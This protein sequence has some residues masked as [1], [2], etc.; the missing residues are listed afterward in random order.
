MARSLRINYPGAFYHVTSRGNEQRDVF[1]SQQDREKFL[2]Y[3]ESA[4]ERYGA[5]I[6]CW[7]L[8]GN[9]LFLE[10]PWGNLPQVMH[11]ING[12]YTTYFNVKRRRSGHLFQGRYK[13]ILVEADAYALELSRYIHLNPVRAGQAGRPEEYR[14]SS[15]GNYVGL[16]VSPNWLKTGFVL[17]CLGTDAV[18]AQAKYRS[19]VE[20][21]LDKEYE[22]PL[23]E[24]VAGAILGRP[25]FV[26]KVKHRHVQSGTPAN[27]IP[28]LRQLAT[29]PTV[30]EILSAVD[31]EFGGK[32]KDARR[33]GLYLSHALVGLPLQELGEIF[34]LRATA[35]CEASRRMG[36]KVA[37]DPE[38][39]AVVARVRAR[40]KS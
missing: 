10:T 32:E 27:D 21:R 33:I 36:K 39:A 18:A 7:C 2:G 20:D 31:D 29:R 24:A 17:G 13:A 19:F 1:K 23:H 16:A 5:D 3:L 26:G 34:G 8:M 30:E 38:L 25:A 4:A 40:L 35:L 37:A 12:A 11:H 22:S 28:A 9:H 14:W 15:Y 6:H